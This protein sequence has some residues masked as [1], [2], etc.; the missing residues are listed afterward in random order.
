MNTDDFSRADLLDSL[1]PF[2][3]G[4]GLLVCALLWLATV[5]L[6]GRFPKAALV[7]S[8]LAF[9]LASAACWLAFQFLGAFFALAT[10]WSLI[11]IALLGGGA[12]E[13]I[14]WIYGF[15]KSL[16][17]PRK[18]RFLLGLRLASLV[19]LLLILVQPVRSFIEERE[20]SREVA[21]LIDDS[22][23]MRL[24]DQRLSPAQKLDRAALLAVPG[25]EKRPPL[26]GIARQ[27]AALDAAL[28]TEVNALRSAPDPQTGLEGRAAQLPEVFKK[29]E[30]DR[31][32][33]TKSLTETLAANLPGEVKGKLDD[34]L[35]RARDG[36][37]RIL[38]LASQALAS[39]NADE[40]VKQCEIARNELAP[41]VQTI[42]A[43][44][45]K[46]DEA[47]YNGLDSPTKKF[48]DEAAATPRAELAK[49]VLS[50]PMP[51]AEA[52]EGEA[53]ETEKGQS[54]G[55]TLLGRLKERYNL[56]YYRFARDV[57]QVSDPLAGE[58]GAA[59]G[60]KPENAQTDLTGALEH[61]L[62]NTSPESLA[63]VLLLGDGRHNGAALPEDGLRQLAVRNAP[64]SAVP[65]G[66][67]LGP[68]DISL[69]SLNAPESIYLDDRVVVT[70]TAKLDGFLGEKVQAELVSGDEV[71]D[72]VTID[73]T[74]VSF[75]TEI[76]FVHKPEAKGIQNYQ[77]RLKPDAREIF[78]ENNSWDFKVA[79][80][81][82]RT[83]VLLVDGFPRWEFRYLRNLF[84]G[85]DKSVHLQYVLL[86]PDEIHR[87]PQPP[88]VYASASRPFGEAEATH[89]PQIK[90][91]WQRFDVIILGDIPPNAL[92]AMDLAAIEE[93]VTKRGALLV[94]VAG[95][96]HMPHGH[97][98]RVLQDLL[99]VA[100]T[101]GTATRYD[102]PEE[103]YRIHLTATGREHAVTSQ[104]T[105]RALNEELWSTFPP[106]RWRYSGAQLKDT[107][108]VLAYAH[109]VG[110]APTAAGFTPDG[111]PGSVEA[112][113]Q[114]LANQKNVEA[115]NAILSTIRAGL[116][117]VLLLHFDQTWRFR[118][119]VGD[120]YHHRFWGQVTRWGAGPNL[121]S[122]NDFVRVGTDRL[123]YT[124]NDAIEVTA[125]VLDPE[126]RPVT[127]AGVEVEIWK[128][129]ERLRKQRLSYRTDSSGLYE[130]SLSGLDEEGEYELKL[131]G[132]EVD[133]AV[134][135]VPDG[136]EE[137][138]TELLVVTT[139]NPIELAELTADRDFLNR[140]TTMT[141]GKLAELDD[142]AS[143]VN[144]FGAPKEVL[145]E[146]RNI[147]LWDKWPLLLAF[148]GLLTTEW[149]T[150]RR[151][152]LV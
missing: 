27:A 16:V 37:S 57:T 139:R 38:P 24:S 85:R 102:T 87:G 10:S 15:E 143:L 82:D 22:D 80:T 72:T 48:V 94:C 13:A 66:A 50:A 120:T 78:K 128:D 54:A 92:S 33:L 152:G 6:R 104:S 83:N 73:V 97:D 109:P 20:I 96:R 100:Y 30:S 53:P 86:N 26:A 32:A 88:T 98:S 90:S 68:V 84:Y 119:G 5:K 103:A 18:G 58:E 126:R 12:A 51:A 136:P 122:G 39:G 148:F 140:A 138:S 150:R 101:P 106:M 117:K 125:K 137:I 23:S 4:P 43:T 70:A 147:T 146:R 77:V 113:I 62:D 95:P 71:I 40:L 35:K 89:L 129:G 127:D 65:L 49:R 64:L 2:L 56:R 149:V 112:A 130:T 81:D 34:Y 3:S 28:A 93:A 135:A 141:G 99:P 118:Y 116:G 114:Q 145:K 19:V 31:A 76:N 91:E 8:I 55:P 59:I 151:S 123:S 52:A 41:L 63:G 45:A 21:V 111:S 121:R 7:L 25:L 142:L 108:E 79:V 9:L 124:P 105:S 144:S 1:G 29:L 44:G 47:F 132:G 115:E 74:D 36:L 133:E 107:A 46:A 61:V 110:S 11:A 69:L 75:R 42:A 14:V 134:A 17:A 67:D 131:V 60:A